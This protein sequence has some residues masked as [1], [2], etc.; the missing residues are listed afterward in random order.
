MP[1]PSRNTYLIGAALLVV[2]AALAV[3]FWPSPVLV[4]L[5]EVTTG[6]LAV[7]VDEEGK[8][9]IKD[10]YTVSAPVSGHMQRPAIEVGD[11]VIAGKTVLAMIEP[12]VPPFLDARTRAEIEANL[13][14]ANAAV[15]AAEAE[16]IK[17]QSELSFAEDDLKRAQRLARTG[18]IPERRLDEAEHQTE[19][20]RRTRDSAAAAVEMRKRERDAV[21]ARLQGGASTAEPQA[22]CCVT[23]TAPASGSVLS[24]FADSE[25]DIA[26]GTP[27]LQIGDPAN[28]EIVVELL[29]SDAVQIAEG[30]KVSIEEWGGAV[31]LEGVVSR[32]EPS[33]FT[34]VS[35]LGI[36]EQ[37]VR[38]LVALT[39]PPDTRARLGH[40]YRVFTRIASW[41]APSALRVSVG[42]LFR[43]GEAWSVYRVRNGTAEIARI[44][45]GH[46]NGELAEVLA[47]LAAGDTVI[48]H[49]S[50]LVTDGA[51][52][53]ERVAE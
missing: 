15:T 10:I 2:A 28:L 23:I 35:A 22:T 40:D 4:D 6:P 44:D 19:A 20:A 38:V 16:H 51:S 32:I 42:A 29:S 34:K 45:I 26:A 33:G 53:R 14:A 5:A 27:L 50:D 36:E 43:S 52:V 7:T 18:T 49:P 13:E 37:R 30:A 41:Q 11:A 31:P 21:L 9:R 47:G 1:K 24:L 3:M 25:R 48:L 12:S 46:R 17:A 39:S 8:T